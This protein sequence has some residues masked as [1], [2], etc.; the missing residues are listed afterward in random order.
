QTRGRS[1]DNDDHVAEVASTCAVGG[2]ASGSTT[3]TKIAQCA[4]ALPAA[5]QR[6]SNSDKNKHPD[7][8]QRACLAVSQGTAGAS[9]NSSLCALPAG[10]GASGPVASQSRPSAGIRISCDAATRS[11]QWHQATLA[12]AVIFL[13]SP[14]RGY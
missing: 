2:A 12:Q 3:R 9:S 11:C 6:K 14:S 7:N 10:A 5:G 8:S 4:A 13:S 1:I